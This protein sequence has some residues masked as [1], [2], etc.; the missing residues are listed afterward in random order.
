M[1]QPRAD[2]R[3]DCAEGLQQAAFLLDGQAIVREATDGRDAVP[4]QFVK[5]D[6]P[7]LWLPIRVFE[8]EK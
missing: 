5:P 4:A 6:Q 8:L 2:G 1:D 7:L 3:F